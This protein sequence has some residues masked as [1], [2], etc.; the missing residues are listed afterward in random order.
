MDDCFFLSRS[1][2]FA[3][4]YS[5]MWEPSSGKGASNPPNTG[6]P[7]LGLPVELGL[8]QNN[9]PGK[10]R[11]GRAE[12]GV[13]SCGIGGREVFVDGAIAPTVKFIINL[14]L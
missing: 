7:K 2:E 10:D 3:I 6:L 14:Y 1:S 11:E 13:K 4:R 12:G 8:R 9:F 5:G